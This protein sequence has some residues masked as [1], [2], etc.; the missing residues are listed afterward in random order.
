MNITASQTSRDMLAETTSLLCSLFFYGPPVVFFGAPW[1]LLALMLM[2]PFTLVVTLV[3]ALAAGAALVAGVALLL[4]APVL[5][6]HRR[7]AARGRVP[8]VEHAAQP[9]D[10]LGRLVAPP[11]R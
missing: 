1:L 11:L 5:M 7:W 9:R 8:D 4:A 10:G 2:G 6:L 3:A